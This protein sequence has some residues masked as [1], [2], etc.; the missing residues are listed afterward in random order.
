MARASKVHGF[1][2]V[3][4]LVVIAIIGILIGLLL[5]AV[6]SAREA[7]RRLQCS[8]NLKQ[9]SLGIQNY[10]TAIGCFPYGVLDEGT[11]GFHK[12]DTWMQQTLPY[13][14]QGALYDQYM[15]WDG[16][17]VMY[18]PDTIKNIVLTAFVCSSDPASP[19]S[20]GG[21]SNDM[22]QGNYVGCTGDDYIEVNRPHDPDYSLYNLDG[23][24]YANSSTQ[25]ADIRDGLSNTLLLSEV[26]VRPYSGTAGWGSGGGYWGGGQ[27]ASFGFTTMEPPNTTVADRVFECKDTAMEQSP[28][29]SVGGD[30]EKCVF[31][32]SYH[33]GGVNV[34]MADGAV[35]FTSETID[36][37]IWQ[38]LGT[39]RGGEIVAGGF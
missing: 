20:G 3:E 24:F 31:A 14:E 15:D 38:G 5:P 35:Q 8:N 37:T 10:L 1:T 23:I 32:R 19:G 21:G 7:A 27:H 13:I 12:R 9:L 33:T 28:C 6:Q 11:T 18:A 17:W 16:E 22:F 39:R 2:L 30:I 26:V 36:L 34:V 4:L 29:I 25:C